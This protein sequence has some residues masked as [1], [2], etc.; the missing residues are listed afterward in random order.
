VAL[1]VLRDILLLPRF[2]TLDVYAA[3]PKNGR[4][5]NDS[6]RRGEYW[7]LFVF[8]CGDGRKVFENA[9]PTH[10]VDPLARTHTRYVVWYQ[11]PSVYT[12]KHTYV[13]SVENRK[14]R[15]KKKK[16]NYQMS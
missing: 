9:M 11:G 8:A 7:C 1:L 3:G 15:K 4:T 16:K 10:Q 14:K 2:T 5:R 6:L 12:C 13:A